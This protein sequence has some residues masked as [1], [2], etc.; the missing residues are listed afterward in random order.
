MPL[1]VPVRLDARP[2]VL[3]LGSIRNSSLSGAYIQ[4]SVTLAPG[5]PVGVELGQGIARHEE[6]CCV[7]AYVVRRDAYGIGVE[8]CEF[9]PEPIQTLLTD[10]ASRAQLGSGVRHR[11]NAATARID[12]R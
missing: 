6:P 1:Y 9:A 5:T 12:W 7:R 2:R 11:R 10:A 8:W 3:A 4:T